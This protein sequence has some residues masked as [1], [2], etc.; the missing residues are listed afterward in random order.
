MP[1]DTEIRVIE[2]KALIAH[3]RFLRYLATCCICILPGGN[4]PRCRFS[5]FF[6][7][8]PLCR[9]AK[10]KPL[11]IDDLLAEKK[12]D[13]RVS[14]AAAAST[15]LATTPAAG[16]QAL[17]S[18]RDGGKG[19]GLKEEPLT[20]KVKNEAPAL[21]RAGSGTAAE[22]EESHMDAAA[23]QLMQRMDDLGEVG[24]GT[25]P[26]LFFLEGKVATALRI[27]GFSHWL[28]TRGASLQIFKAKSSSAQKLD[29]AAFANGGSNQH[30]QM[31][32]TAWRTAVLKSLC[33]VNLCLQSSQGLHCQC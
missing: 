16:A 32:G 31:L 29:R 30:L 33:S 8:L 1:S 13:Q 25:A 23:E 14:A 27:R 12:E 19:A 5:C 28:V 11:D 9:K 4:Y 10:F 2:V 17:P 18:A 26:W 24:G 22:G 15:G 7:P 21:R 6:G 3:L 20:E